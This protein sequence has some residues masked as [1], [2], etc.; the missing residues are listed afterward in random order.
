MTTTPPTDQRTR[1]PAPRGLFSRALEQQARAQAWS[2]IWRDNKA[3]VLAFYVIDIMGA[4]VRSVL[5]VMVWVPAIV[6]WPLLL[7][8]NALTPD[9]VMEWVTRLAADGLGGALPKLVAA[10]FVISLSV[11]LLKGSVGVRLRR[12]VDRH[13]E[14]SLVW[15]MLETQLPL[16]PAPPP[17][18]PTPSSEP[19]HDQP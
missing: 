18:D 17:V 16:A 10:V 14:R 15:S 1:S 11:Q 19:T 5:H 9:V 4:L 12:T 3:M 2:T 13:M 6:L 7:S 8:S